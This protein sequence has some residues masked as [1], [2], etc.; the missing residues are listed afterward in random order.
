VQVEEQNEAM[1][2]FSRVKRES[3]RSLTRIGKLEAVSALTLSLQRK[4]YKKFAASAA[5]VR[6]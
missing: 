1:R 3:P 6:F 5:T 4:L 2:E